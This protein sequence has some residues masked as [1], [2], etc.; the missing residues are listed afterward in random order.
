[1]IEE[2]GPSSFSIPLVR[3]ADPQPA[4]LAE[5]QGDAL[6]ERTPA[7]FAIEHAGYLANASTRLLKARGE[8]DSLVMRRDEDDDV[9]DS[10]MHAAQDRVDEASDSVRSA[11]YEFEKRRDRALAATGKQQVGEVESVDDDWRLRGYAYASKQATTCAGCGKHKHTPLRIDAMGGYVC[12]T[13]IDQ[14]LGALMNEFGYQ[15]E[16]VGE[17]QGDGLVALESAMPYLETLHSIVGGEARTSVWRCIERGR[18]A[19]AARQPGAQVPVGYLFT[20]DPA[21]YAMPGSGFHPGK[22]PP[23]DAINVVPLY[24]APPAQGIDLGQLRDLAS[25]LLDSARFADYSPE[26]TSVGESAGRRLLALIDQRDAA[27]GVANA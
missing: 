18:A 16:Q 1:M 20:D 24:D 8:L 27:P 19:L 9:D 15:S 25:D 3:A 14:K 7:D 4:E 11:I 6:R 12:L 2:H 22:E 13:C 17:V 23:A 10:D 26:M 21:V 5:Q